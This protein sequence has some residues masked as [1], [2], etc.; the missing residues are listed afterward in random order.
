M[1][2]RKLLSYVGKL[3]WLTGMITLGLSYCSQSNSTEEVAFTEEEEVSAPENYYAAWEPRDFYGYRFYRGECYVYG[4]RNWGGYRGWGNY[5]QSPNSGST[6]PS[7]PTSGNLVRNGS[8]EQPPLGRYT[9]WRYFG[10]S[11]LSGWRVEE[12]TYRVGE[13]QKGSLSADGQQHLEMDARATYSVSQTI[14]TEPGKTYRLRFAFSVR[15]YT[16]GNENVLITKWDDQVVSTIDANASNT[17]NIRWRYY[18]FLLPATKAQTT[19]SF[20][21]GGRSNSYGALLDNVSVSLASVGDDSSTEAEAADLAIDGGFEGLGDG[22]PVPTNPTPVETRHSVRLVSFPVD[23]KW[24]PTSGSTVPLKFVPAGTAGP[25]EGRQCIALKWSGQNYGISQYVSTKPGYKYV[26]SVS[27]ASQPGTGDNRIVIKWN[28]RPIATI[29][30]N[31]L[32]RVASGMPLLWEEREV[33]VEASVGDSS[34]LTFQAVGDGQ[35][36]GAF[37]DNVRI[38]AGTQQKNLLTDGTFSADSGKTPWEGPYTRRGGDSSSTKAFVRGSRR[39]SIAENTGSSILGISQTVTTV[40]GKEYQL[41]FF[42]IRHRFINNSVG[43]GQPIFVSGSNSGPTLTVK[44]SDEEIGPISDLSAL[45]E[46]EARE[47]SYVFTATSETSKLAF[48]PSGNSSDYRERIALDNVRLYAVN[49]D[50]DNT[51][52]KTTEVETNWVGISANNPYHPRTSAEDEYTLIPDNTYQAAGLIMSNVTYRGDY[53]ISGEYQTCDDDGGNIWNSAD[54][55]A[56]VLG[57]TLSDY[58]PEPNYGPNDIPEIPQLPVGGAKGVMFNG[59]GVSVDFSTYGYSRGISIRDGQG[60]TLANKPHYGTYT[61]CRWASFSVDV[62][63]SEN[64]LIVKKGTS[65]Q[66]SVKLT[67]QAATDLS[68]SSGVGI[69][70]GTGAADSAHKVRKLRVSP[71]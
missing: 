70:A 15:R 10:L 30:K 48:V 37:I 46:N 71:L 14:N 35:E 65:T 31:A 60:R 39:A 41:K 56:I 34:K 45:N 66:L 8:F 23:S 1:E 24:Q 57:K 58:V 61:G 22:Q 40:V 25:V 36:V 27:H 4:L 13:L 18:E 52:S 11:E 67:G 21:G 20:A 59:K 28:D 54:G 29:E 12:P 55:I 42:A 43:D 44:F 38:E 49:P 68:R 62:R 50:T 19:L 2:K 69:S 47:F 17:D 7:N 6:N 26:I 16:A 9:P 5:N 33:V 32:D 3:V 51:D 64:K 63:N 53:R